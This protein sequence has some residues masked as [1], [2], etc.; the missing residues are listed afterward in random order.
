MLT[1][2]KQESYAQYSANHPSLGGST[3]LRT[4][5]FNFSSSSRGRASAVALLLRGA[6]A[7]TA[8]RMAASFRR[9]SSSR[10]S[11]RRCAAEHGGGWRWRWNRWWWLGVVG[12]SGGGRSLPGGG[13]ALDSFCR[14]GGR[15]KK[16]LFIKLIPGKMNQ[17]MRLELRSS[18][19]RMS[20]SEG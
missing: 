3:R 8:A 11:P 18:C 13:D 17:S 15:E 14:R 19:G 4:A 10:S 12:V 16:K 20:S 1:P 7:R 9:R 2:Q 6:G 5:S